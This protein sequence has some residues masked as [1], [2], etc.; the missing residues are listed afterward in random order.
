M[1][2]KIGNVEDEWREALTMVWANRREE[3]SFLLLILVITLPVCI[4]YC[5]FLFY[6][7]FTE[8]EVANIAS[9]NS[10]PELTNAFGLKHAR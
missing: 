1:E 4:I 8:L 7:I 5:V 6:H 10:Q 2:A 9:W 3:P